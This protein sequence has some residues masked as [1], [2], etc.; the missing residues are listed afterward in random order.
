MDCEAQRDMGK[1]TSRGNRTVLTRLALVNLVV[2]ATECATL[3]GDGFA[4]SPGNHD[5]ES[6]EDLNVIAPKTGHYVET[7]TTAGSKEPAFQPAVLR[8]INNVSGGFFVKTQETNAAK[9]IRPI[10]PVIDELKIQFADGTAFDFLSMPH[11]LHDGTHIVNGPAGGIVSTVS[12]PLRSNNG[13]SIESS[14]ARRVAEVVAQRQLVETIFG[15]ELESEKILE[16]GSSTI[17]RGRNASAIQ[18]EVRTWR[19]YERLTRT[20]GKG[21]VRGM[22]TVA[23]WKTNSGAGSR[24][25]LAVFLER[26]FLEELGDE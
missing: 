20:H 10:S 26:S 25:H 9:P 17:T 15:V 11:L 1:T 18:Q 2:F 22:R 14:T 6:Q 7:E 24:L 8:R 4:R 21:I 3:V 5:S 19:N 12:V 13:R 23:L 16:E